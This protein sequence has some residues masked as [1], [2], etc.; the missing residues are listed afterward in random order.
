MTAPV[1]SSAAGDTY[2]MRFF[3]PSSFTAETAPKPANRDVR[4]GV[5]AP[6]L[7]AV[8]RFSGSTSDEAVEAR[9]ANLLRW[10]SQNGWRT[11]GEPVA[12]F[13]D[14]P[15]TLPFLKRNEMAVEIE[16]RG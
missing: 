10:L 11:V 3:L 15:W 5:T 6:R 2:R 4:L 14:P 12:Y 7:E 8:L 9:K 13:Y 1:Q 16:P